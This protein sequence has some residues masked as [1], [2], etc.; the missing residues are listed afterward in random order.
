MNKIDGEELDWHLVRNT[1]GEWISNRHAEFMSNIEITINRKSALMHHLPLTVNSGPD[2]TKWCYKH[3]LNA[4][5]AAIP[6]SEVKHRKLKI[7]PNTTLWD[8][9]MIEQYLESRVE[10]EIGKELFETLQKLSNCKVSKPD[11]IDFKFN[12]ETTSLY[13]HIRQKQ[14]SKNK[15]VHPNYTCRNM[16]TDNA[17]FEGWAICIKAWLQ[18]VEKVVLKWDEPQGF[19]NKGESEQ[20]YNRF[21]YRVMRFSEA[22]QDW[23]EVDAANRE[24][25]ENFKK[26]FFNLQNNSYGDEPDEPFRSESETRTE[27]EMANTFANQMKDYFKLHTIGRQL[28]IGVKRDGSQFFTGGKSAIDLWGMNND[29]LTVIELKYNY[30][31]SINKKVGIISELF[32]YACTMRDMIVGIIQAPLHPLTEQEIKLYEKIKDFKQVKAE[33]L[34]NGFHPLLDNPKV[35]ELLNAN[36]FQEKVPIRFSRTL[37]QYK[38]GKLMLPAES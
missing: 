27:Y 26:Q 10:T 11:Y 12:V 18:N 2:G 34:S 29:E 21:L 15:E 17:A 28:P 16:Q 3:E 36:T 4:I 32:L 25:I 22:Y 30:G 31:K 9:N 38:T 1:K 35:F 33:M 23:F 8:T 13:L 14:S 24:T 37:Y 19:S 7:K 6:K 20:H 5:D